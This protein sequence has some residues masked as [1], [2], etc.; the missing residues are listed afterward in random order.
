MGGKESSLKV[1]TDFINENRTKPG[2]QAMAFIAEIVS[3]KS[4]T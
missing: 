4:K 3:L 2:V 1:K